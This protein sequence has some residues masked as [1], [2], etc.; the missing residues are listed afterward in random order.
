MAIITATDKLKQLFDETYL[1]KTAKTSGFCKRLREIQPLRLVT[2]MVSA[3]GDGK[4]DSIAELH[5]SFNGI[6]NLKEDAVAYKPFHNQLRKDGFPLF[7]KIVVTR[8]MLMFKQ[9]IQEQ[10]PEKL[11]CFDQILIQDGSSF[12]LHP[13]LSEYFP[14]RFTQH[15]PAAVECHLRMS[16]LD[17]LPVTMEV[18]ADKESERAYLPKPESMKNKLLLADAGYIGQAYMQKVT[19]WSGYF[20]LRY[21]KIINPTIVR[22]Q[23]A[24]GKSLPKLKNLKLKDMR[25]H[26]SRA[27]V[28]DLDIEWKKFRCRAVRFWH[29]TEKRYLTWLTN[30]P[31][32]KFSCDDVMKLYRLR[33][34]VELLFKEWKSYNNLHAFVTRQPQIAEGLIWASLLSLL[35]KRYIGKVAQNYSGKIRLST[36]KI[37][38]STRGWLDPLMRSLATVFNSQLKIDLRWAVDYIIMNCE[39][40]QQSKAKQDKGLEGIL[41]SL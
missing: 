36:F 27:N 13:E 21:S 29:P 16:L 30:L 11:K 14:G 5:R 20:L 10:L 31:R 18:S 1:N 15:S 26:H 8:A 35:L 9:Q 23:T 24:R 3:L 28:L 40:S 7:M 34:Q 37:A 6:R 41:G 22:A 17:D 25:R 33:W 19:H 12:A 2:S 32:E 4:T 39:R 38:K